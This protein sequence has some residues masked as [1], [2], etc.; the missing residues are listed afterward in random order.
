MYSLD[1]LDIL[2]VTWGFFFQV[3]LIV[4][5]AVRKWRFKTAIRYGWVVYAL[6]IPAAAISLVLLAAGKPWWLWLGGFLCLAWSAFG[7]WVEYVRKIEWRQ[8]IVASIFAPY[9][10]LYL[11]T[12]MFYWWP[13]RLLYKPLW[14]AFTV[15]F[16]ISTVLNV[17][18]HKGE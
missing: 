3:V 5:F 16:I 17:T 1:K 11:A 9:I 18:S 10:S 4:H 15:L 7:Y 6:G 12:I 2:F 13:M 8:P 14:Y